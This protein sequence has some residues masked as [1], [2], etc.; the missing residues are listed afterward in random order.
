MNTAWEN[1]SAHRAISYEEN[2]SFILSVF[3]RENLSFFVWK[4]FRADSVFSSLIS[5]VLP[6]RCSHS[7][8]SVQK[9]FIVRKKW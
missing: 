7:F 2:L 4:I 1:P 6:F 3:F 8:C 9:S 5:P